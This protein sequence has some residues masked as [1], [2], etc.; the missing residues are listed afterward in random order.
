MSSCDVLTS[1]F[2]RNLRGFDTVDEI[3]APDDATPSVGDF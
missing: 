2:N 3:K 1:M